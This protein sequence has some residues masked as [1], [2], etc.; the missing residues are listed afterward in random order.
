MY[1][2]Y[3]QSLQ[4]YMHYIC[5]QVYM[6]IF[7]Y[8]YTYIYTV[9]VYIY[10]YA[11]PSRYLSIYTSICICVFVCNYVYIFL[12]SS[13]SLDVAS[14]F[15]ELR[16]ALEAIGLN[17]GIQYSIF[18]VLAAIL[19]LG[20]LTFVTGIRTD[21]VKDVVILNKDKELEIAYKLLGETN[22]S[23]YLSKVD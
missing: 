22:S 7:I 21:G 23:G 10:V 5:I 9:Y 1:I 16:S 20:N 19:T 4:L 8:L 15:Q 14:Q 11:N 13:M 17:R 12:D 2:Y 18:K 6:Y 3:I